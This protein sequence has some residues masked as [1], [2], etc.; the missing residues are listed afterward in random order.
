MSLRPT[1]VKPLDLEL[2]ATPACV[3]TARHAVTD[4]CADQD[5]DN[6]GVALAVSEAVSN[7]VMHAYRNR[8]SGAVRLFASVAEGA[9]VVVISD[10][11]HGMT[12]LTD[13]P[14]MGWGLSLMAQLATTVEI[15]DDK[16]GT[17]VVLS[18]EHGA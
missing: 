1:R 3:A 16:D 4:Y 17:R 7:A 2:A 11:G 13:S 10:D 8:E 12:P 18:F 6:D 5:L 14:G 9:L 15:D